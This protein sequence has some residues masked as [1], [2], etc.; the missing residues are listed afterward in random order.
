MKKLLTIL[1]SVG[2]VATT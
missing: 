1:G 2:L